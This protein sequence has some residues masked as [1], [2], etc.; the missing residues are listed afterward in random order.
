M[1]VVIF[2]QAIHKP[3]TDFP[4]DPTHGQTQGGRHCRC[5]A[6]HRAAYHQKKTTV[7]N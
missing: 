6:C 4:T 2:L 1:A 5:R 7:A 3:L